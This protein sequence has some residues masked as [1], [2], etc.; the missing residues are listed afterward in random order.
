MFKLHKN[1]GVGLCNRY[2]LN[3]YN[4]YDVYFLQDPN[5]LRYLGHKP[6]LLPGLVDEGNTKDNL[7]A[8][9]TNEH[10]K[11]TAVLNL[12]KFVFL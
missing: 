5:P 4:M 6:P 12:F 11:P 7:N 8:L 3:Y 1:G 2:N 9:F 10:N